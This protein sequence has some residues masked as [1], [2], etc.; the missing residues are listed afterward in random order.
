[1][2]LIID[3]K[4]AKRQGIAYAPHI[5]TRPILVWKMLE[6]S[7]AWHN[8]WVSPYRLMP[9]A[10]GK[11]H[12]SEL[13]I[14]SCPYSIREGLHAFWHKETALDRVYSDREIFPAII[15]IG[16][17]FFIGTNG[18]IVS[19][20]LTVYKTI[21]QLE[22]IHGKIDHNGIARESLKERK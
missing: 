2:C 14:P 15:P 17:E 19:N 16:A 20:K 6:P 9:Y 4:F 7:F 13:K 10:F 8:E 5:A 1:M 3:F 12:E 21:R 11:E 22:N 18:E